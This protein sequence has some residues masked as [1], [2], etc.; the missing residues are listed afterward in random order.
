MSDKQSIETL[1]ALA[2]KMYIFPH[3]DA[4]V[5]RLPPELV[6]EAVSVGREYASARNQFNKVTRAW[7]NLQAG[8]A[9]RSSRLEAAAAA[10]IDTVVDLFA[11]SG[12]VPPDIPPCAAASLATEY[13]RL[14]RAIAELGATR[15]PAATRRACR[16]QGRRLIAGAHLLQEVVAQRHSWT[17]M[18]LSAAG[19]F[20][21][22]LQVVERENGLA[23][24]NTER[25]NKLAGEMLLAGIAL[26]QRV[27]EIER[28]SELSLGFY[29]DAYERWDWLF[30]E[31]A[32]LIQESGASEE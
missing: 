8:A 28:G 3:A 20:E 19:E 12:E 26:T 9:D 27:D 22:G 29:P 1:S 10:D 11:T 15:L 13:S 4:F 16:A 21:D 2:E 7:N 30:K 25:L 6:S 32:P 31:L 14:L 24:T 5:P 17:S 23:V 18:L